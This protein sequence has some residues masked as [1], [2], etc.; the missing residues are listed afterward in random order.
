[1]AIQRPPTLTGG[2]ARRIGLGAL[3]ALIITVVLV[4]CG[5][6][7]TLPLPTA[8]PAPAA[9]STAGG[10]VARIATIVAPGGVPGAGVA[11]G[12]GTGKGQGSGVRPTKG[13][14]PSDHPLKG[15]RDKGQRVY[16]VAGS[17][18][19]EQTKAET[20]FATEMD[21]QAAGYHA[22]GQ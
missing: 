2:T 12:V 4:A 5:G 21:A 14:C 6:G 15:R 19:Y 13:V 11:N 7:S 10:P 1:M 9:P 3:L 17:P 8:P 20:C 22:A 16:Y 18:S